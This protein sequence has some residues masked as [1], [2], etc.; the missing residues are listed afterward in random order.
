MYD[1]RIWTVVYFE[2]ENN[3]QNNLLVQTQMH[4]QNGGHFITLKLFDNRSDSEFWGKSS[5]LQND[6]HPQATTI[7]YMSFIYTEM[8]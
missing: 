7:H 5:R 8:M 6:K 4:R 1:S 3:S 2:E